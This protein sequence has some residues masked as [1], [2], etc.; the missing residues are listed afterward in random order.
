M[1]DFADKWPHCPTMR[2]VCLH[3]K[4]NILS[5]LKL[6]VF[7][8]L[9]ALLWQRRSDTKDI[10]IQELLNGNDAFFVNYTD[11]NQNQEKSDFTWSQTS[12]FWT[13]NMGSG[14]TVNSKS[15]ES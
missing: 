8:N 11:S 5:F 14:F 9:H 3:S 1:A 13:E 2:E 7:I 10:R 4:A 12:V 15:Q 6:G